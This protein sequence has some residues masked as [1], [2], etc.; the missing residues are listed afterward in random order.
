MD[1]LGCR[2]VSRPLG[3]STSAQVEE[4]NQAQTPDQ[5]PRFE[6]PFRVI[7]GSPARATERPLLGVKRTK[8][9]AK[10]TSALTPHSSPNWTS[11]PSRISPAVPAQGPARAIGTPPRGHARFMGPSGAH[12]SRK[13]MTAT[14]RPQPYWIVTAEGLCLRRTGCSRRD[15]HRQWRL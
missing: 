12:F 14:R 10:R 9:G 11:R 13:K 7:T 4:H 5:L 8:S 15:Y 1:A 6:C 2:G 3:G